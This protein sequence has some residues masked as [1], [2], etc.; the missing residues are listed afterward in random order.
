MP[1]AYGDYLDCIN[2]GEKTCPLWVAPLPGWDLDY[3]NREREVSCGI[4]A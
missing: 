3:T 2:Q 4:L 1:M